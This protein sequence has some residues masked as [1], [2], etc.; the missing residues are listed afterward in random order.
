MEACFLGRRV[1]DEDGVRLGVGGR[2]EGVVAGKGEGGQVGA[3]GGN[4][5][6]TINNVTEVRGDK[7]EMLLDS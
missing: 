1:A 2:V 7:N 3:V 6:V 4:H 5:V